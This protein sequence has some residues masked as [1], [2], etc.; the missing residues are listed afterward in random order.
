VSNQI[1][2]LSA[3]EIIVWRLGKPLISA[4]ETLIDVELFPQASSEKTRSG[5]RQTSEILA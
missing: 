3:F 4:D 1:L 2:Q 5:S